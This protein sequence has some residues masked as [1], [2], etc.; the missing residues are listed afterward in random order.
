MKGDYNRY[1]AEYDEGDLKK[2]IS[3]DALKAYD[4]ETKITKTL[5]VLIP[6]ALDLVFNFSVFYYEVINDHKKAIKIT[7]ASAEKADKE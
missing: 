1:I 3:D 6:I 4:E 5:L 7:K 2:Q